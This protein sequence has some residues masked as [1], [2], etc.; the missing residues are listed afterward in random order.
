MNNPELI[1][2]HRR[3]PHWRLEGSTY[4]VT[5]RLHRNQ[6]LL[7][8]EE[9]DLIKS[10]LFHFNDKRYSIYAWVIMDDHV[11][12]L[13]DLKEN[14][15]IQNVVHSWKSYSANELRKKF[16]RKAPIWQVEYFD[17]IIR[18]E[19]EFLEKGNYILNN[20]RK[21]WPEIEDYRWVGL[22]AE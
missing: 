5:W 14:H 6:I 4:F 1:I 16:A 21:R 15:T 18:H 3:L 22:G 2:Y 7:T 13:F 11:H 19:A 17:R 8:P 20:P 9:K 12:V 10:V